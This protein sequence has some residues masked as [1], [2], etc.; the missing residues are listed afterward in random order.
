MKKTR[1]KDK[2]EYY[3]YALCYVDDILCCDHDTS[4][5]MRELGG[6]FALKPGAAGTPNIY[7]G[8][9]LS[10]TTLEN[11]VRVWD[12]SSSKYVQ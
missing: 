6:Y 1:P 2:F 8:A 10:E 9:K 5:V 3:S 11:S 7:L 4:E 12:M